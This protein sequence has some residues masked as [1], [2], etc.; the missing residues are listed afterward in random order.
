[1]LP[2]Y[3]TVHVAYIPNGYIT[4][5]S[6]IARVVDMLLSSF[7]GARAYDAANKGMHPANSQSA[8]RNGGGRS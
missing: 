3:G 1:M 8:G 7:A 5:L 4:G 6:K 2:F